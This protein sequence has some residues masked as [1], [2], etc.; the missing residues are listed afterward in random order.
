MDDNY[1]WP[2]MVMVYSAAINSYAKDFRIIVGNINS[3]LSQ[4][5]IHIAE[6]FTKS[7]GLDLDIINITTSLNPRFD[8]QFNLTIY[9]RL[10]LMDMLEEDFIWFDSDLL[11]MPGWDTIFT[12]THDHVK[13][14]IA[15]YGVLD[16]KITRAKL[17][18]DL[19]KA[20]LRSKGMYVNAGIIKI[21]TKN[22]RKLQKE[23]DWQE[24]AINIDDYGLSLHDQD[25]INYICAGHIKLIAPGFNYIV[26]DQISFQEKI[27]I[28]HFAGS[29]KPWQLDK[30]GKEFLLAVQGAKYFSPRD[31][32]TQSS[33]AFLYFPKYWQV[34][35]E[36]LNY[37]QNF[38]DG[39][40]QMV[41][42]LRDR[43]LKKLDFVSR[44][45]HYLIQ[46]IS[47]RFL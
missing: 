4:E 33:D 37:L 43:N 35:A 9:S 16:S 40:S 39:L 44:I 19:N 23:V 3:M 38:D 10:F 14:N 8:H 18:K 45:K 22:W 30:A 32:L 7:L 11:L 25:I 24:M 47:W 36:L 15:L 26:G 27:L 29:P 20:Y 31:W 42:G 41:A 6:R 1:L 17:E 2:W 28:K 12:E 5:S 13:E 34:E 46:L 21:F